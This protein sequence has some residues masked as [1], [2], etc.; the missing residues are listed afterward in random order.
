MANLVLCARTA[1]QDGF[2]DNTGKFRNPECFSR[3]KRCGAAFSGYLLGCSKR[4][5]RQRGETRNAQVNT[6][7]KCINET[8]P[9][10]LTPYINAK[11]KFEYHVRKQQK[12]ITSGLPELLAT[13]K[14]QA[15]DGPD[16]GSCC[17]YRRTTP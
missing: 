14:E 13:E 4:V 12:R 11:K 1:H 16:A 15:A 5:T 9:V 8:H 10:S 7:R 3:G 6:S 2:V 17:Q